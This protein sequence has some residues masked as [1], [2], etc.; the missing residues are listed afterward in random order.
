MRLVDGMQLCGRCINCNRLHAIVTIAFNRPKSLDFFKMLHKNS[1]SI[2][3]CCAREALSVV[4]GLK[5]CSS[6]H[7]RVKFPDFNQIEL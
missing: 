7:G 6:D 1:N 3:L 5:P 2:V 4:N